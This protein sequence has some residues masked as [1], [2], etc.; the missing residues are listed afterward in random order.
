MAFSAGTEMKGFTLLEVLVAIS[1]FALIG[2]GSNQL[3]RT[4]IN[5]RDATETRMLELNKLQRTFAI[6]DRDLLQL[7]NRPIRN[8]FGDPLPAVELSTG[9]YNLELSRLGWRNPSAMP[10]SNVQ[11]VAYVLNGQKLER[12]Y[13]TV[14]DRAEDSEPRVQVL[15]EGVEDFRVNALDAKGDTTAYW[16][17]AGQD[18][19]LDGTETAGTSVAVQTL[20]PALEIVV[21]TPEFGEI[22]HIAPLV[23][24]ADLL[25]SVDNGG[26]DR[27]GNQRQDGQDQEQ[28]QDQYQNDIQDTSGSGALD[29]SDPNT[30]DEVDE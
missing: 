29:N 5:S 18:Q 22:R 25:T 14:M 23:E 8:G 4:V 20:P 6:M 2:L 12:H 15:L 27:D 24:V 3:L 13:W 1:I 21:T 9:D 10:R 17:P 19:Q 28:D 7:S 11:R 26:Q 16:P 30:A